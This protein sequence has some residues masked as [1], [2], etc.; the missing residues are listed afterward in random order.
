MSRVAESVDYHGRDLEAMSFASNYHSWIL[1]LFQPYLGA[2]VVEVGAGTGL[3]SELL[4]RRDPET[5]TLV[6]PSSMYDQLVER[7]GKLPTASRVQTHNSTFSRVADRIR[8]ETQPDSIV[9]VNVLEHVVDDEAE[10]AVVHA[11]LSCAGRLFVFVPALSWLYGSFDE[12]VGHH[13]RYS[14]RE[15]EGKIERSGFCV[16]KSIYFDLAGIV[17]WWLQYRLLRSR[18]MEPEAVKFY[19]RFCVPWLKKVETFA[20]PPIG[21]NLLLVAE[22]K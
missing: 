3:F 4:L 10:L 17:P 8:D 15:L 13:R 14:R 19:D 7:I 9:Y 1:E 21:K 11:T 20:S 16:L 12:M 22:R 5:L 6:E 2:R 18:R